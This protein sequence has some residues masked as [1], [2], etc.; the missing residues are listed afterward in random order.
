MIS[1]L[2]AAAHTHPFQLAVSGEST[3]IAPAELWRLRFV[4][5]SATKLSRG[6]S[7]AVPTERVLDLASAPFFSLNK[8][9][10]WLFLLRFRCASLHFHICTNFFDSIVFAPP[11]VRRSD[12]TTNL[13][14]EDFLLIS[15][16]SANI[17]DSGGRVLSEFLRITDF[18]LSTGM[19]F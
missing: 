11:N 17:F 19:S 3:R 14:I 10:N 7:S 16:I 15:S 13:P 1:L 2:P 5:F 4:F 18:P 9:V 6:L 8:F 12:S